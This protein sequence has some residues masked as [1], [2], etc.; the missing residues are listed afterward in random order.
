[1]IPIIQIQNLRKTFVSGKATVVAVDDISLAVNKGEIFGFLGP[2]GAG[3]TTTMR[4]LT[5]LLKPTSGLVEIAG[6]NLA[7]E[8]EKVRTQL[9]YVSQS[10]GLER[11]ASARE[12]LVLQARIFNFNKK[13]A[14]QRADELI[15]ALE[16]E[17]FADR[18]VSTY[19]GGQRRRTDL[20]L[21]MMHRPKILFLDEPTVG[22]DPH[23]RAHLWGEI[24]KLRD[25]GTTIFVT[26]HYLDE[27]D[28]L[29][30]RV[31]IVDH[32]RIVALGT[33]SDL[34]R[35]IGSDIIL[36]GMSSDTVES[37]NTE[38]IFGALAGMRE[39]I[40]EKEGLRLLV[41]HGDTLLP[42]VLRLCD[43]A[44]IDLSA[45]SL[46]R[47]TLDDVFLQKTGRSFKQENE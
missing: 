33:P 5:T 41:Q 3:K 45:I 4:M 22:L 26:T 30:D 20:A 8:E 36:L 6:Y 39:I 1:M 9:G 2:N 47:P 46:H 40:K 43:K 32:G 42:Q 27:A 18:L 29:C 16:L 15:K 14:R 24:R 23:S 10:G 12:N 25:Q 44:G 31:A 35:E 17:S 21:G 11:S 7:T 34:K 38:K 28:A 13:E 37:L 19:S